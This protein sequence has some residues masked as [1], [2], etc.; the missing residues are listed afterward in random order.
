MLIENSM[1]LSL[2][3]LNME[4]GIQSHHFDSISFVQVLFVHCGSDGNLY[5]IYIE[6]MILCAL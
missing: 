1:Q 3:D 4:I 2:F 5:I 6:I